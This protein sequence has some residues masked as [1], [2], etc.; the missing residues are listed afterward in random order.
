MSLCLQWF[1]G[2]DK[3]YF[4]QDGGGRVPPGISAYGLPVPLF[5]DFISAIILYYH[6]YYLK[7]KVRTL[8][9]Y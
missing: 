2:G 8:D 9:A 7:K 4:P 3:S 5:L 1:I 6:M